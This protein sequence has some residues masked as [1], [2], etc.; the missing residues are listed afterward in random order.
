MQQWVVVFSLAR[1]VGS[2]SPCGRLL[3]EGVRNIFHLD[4]ALLRKFGQIGG[5]FSF[6]L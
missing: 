3:W 4:P 6:E 1:E 5:A 2:V